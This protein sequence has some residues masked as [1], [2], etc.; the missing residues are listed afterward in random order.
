MTQELLTPLPHRDPFRFLDSAELDLAA[1]TLIG[2]WTPAA[3]WAVFGGH[4]PN[5]PVVPGVILVEAMAQAACLLGAHLDPAIQGREVYLVG[6]DGA[7]FRTPVRP[8]ET[9]EVRATYDKRRRD[10]WWFKARAAVAG[11]KVAEASLLASVGGGK[12]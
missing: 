12:P 8:G 9:V 11:K 10:L 6:V 3:D 7:R 1:K 4:F 5:N 2:H